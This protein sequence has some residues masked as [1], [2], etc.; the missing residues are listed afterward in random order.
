MTAAR[1]KNHRIK[2]L[3][4]RTMPLVAL[5]AALFVALLLV[6]GVQSDPQD[7]S[8]TGLNNSFIRVLVVTVFALVVLLW[9]IGYRLLALIRSV[10]NGTPGALLSARW[11]RNFIALS[12]P[13]ALI[14]FFF[15]AW[16]LS[17]TIDSW[18]DVRVEAALEDSL[19]L[20]QQFLDT[21]T[22]EVRNQLRDTARDIANL[23]EDGEL[24][25]RALL[26]RVRSAGPVELTVMETSGALVAT[27]NINALSGLPQ[28]PGD[29]AIMQA[30]EQGEYAAAEPTADASLQIRVVQL[31]PATYPGTSD[32]LLQAIYPLPPDIT[33]LAGSIEQEY[34]RY[35]NVSY[36]RQSL[37]QSF[38]LVLSLVLL[39][40]ILLAILAALH[41]ARR[42]V[43]PLSSLSAATRE[44]AAG[45]FGKEVAAGQRDEIG[46]LV[47]S[48]NQ[49]T[50]ALKTASHEAEESRAELAAQG[51]YLE[52]VLGNL[53]S[54]VLTLDEHGRV[55]TANAACKQILGLPAGQGEDFPQQRHGARALDDLT[56]YAPYLESFV[57]AIRQQVNRGRYE[58]QQEIKL[59]RQGAP[60]VLLMRGSRLPMT[61]LAGEETGE[62]H[63]VVFDD[64]TI[65]NQAQRD[66][67][68]SEV[69]RRLAHEVR[70]PLTPIRLAA[71]RLRM[72]LEGK[73]EA[74]DSAILDKASG[75]IVSQVEALRK[76]VDAFGDYA[77]E[78]RLSLEPVRLDALIREVVA[79]Y[80][81]GDSCLVFDLDLCAGP[82]GL[83]AD[84]G[85]LRQLL[86]NL[87]RNAKEAGGEGDIRISISTEQMN[88]GERNRLKMEIRDDGPGFPALILEQPFQ[89]YISNKGRGSGLGLA[90]CRKIVSEHNGGI[91][92]SNL[93]GGGA[94]V[95]IDFPLAPGQFPEAKIT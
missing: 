75:T 89:P 66:A 18:F 19:Q 37:K 6:S 4:F 54:G 35:Q 7:S 28:R 25:R 12:L 46:F 52:T 49:M 2:R 3:A 10:R 29:F 69:A 41:A 21:R 63:V 58:W 43:S 40:T 94:R 50:Q 72:K 32:R 57:A 11:V 15:S 85:R 36:L 22:L 51:K 82:D 62:G 33:S 81:Q 78:P 61:A 1:G 79:L 20:G 73:L 67:A 16:F 65:L 27:A 76:L 80:Q 5:L 13:P 74:G 95:T 38:L 93:A 64:V 87:I 77:Q 14:V 17:S 42:M 48:F 45:D 26:A 71:E 31:M 44:V 39:L 23:Q 55:M 60:L 56:T 8:G 86:H 30:V 88:A 9:S 34:H 24:L 47:E 84:N 83:A 90:I 59:D 68:W 70:N 91:A 53:S 92:I